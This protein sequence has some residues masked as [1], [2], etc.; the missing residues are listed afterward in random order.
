MRRSALAEIS[1][2]CPKHWRFDSVGLGHVVLS[3]ICWSPDRSVWIRYG[4]GIQVHRGVWAGDR[5]DITSADAL[6][7]K[8]A[9]GQRVEWKDVTEEVLE[10]MG[11]IWTRELGG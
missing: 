11:Q 5:F 8:A 6:E 10:E 1:K 9:N 4:G 7:E 2:T 3:R